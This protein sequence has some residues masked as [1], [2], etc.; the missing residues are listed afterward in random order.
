MGELIGKVV[1]STL[2][3]VPKSEFDR[4]R[5]LNEASA[6]DKT[7]I[8]ADMCRLNTLYMIARAGSGHVGSSFSS[9]DVVSWLYL[10]ELKNDDLYFSSK[11]HDAPGLYSVLIALGK[12]PFDKLHGLRR[13]GGLPGH[14][15]VGVP[16]MVINSG[17]L[18]MGISKAKGMV[19]ADR[20]KGHKRHYY[21]LTGDGELQEGQIWESLISAANAGMGEITAIVDHNKLQSD[22]RVS[23][24]SDLGDLVEKF[25]SFGWYVERCDGHDLDEFASTLRSCATHPGRPQVIIADTVKG[26]GVS[27]MEH[28]AMDSDTDMY[29]FH[30]G[31]PD[32]DSYSKGAQELLDHVN[33]ALS[34]V[35]A[36]RLS[37]ERVE[38]PTKATPGATKKLI[39]AYTEA[40][41]AAAAKDERI[42]ALD[43]DLVLDT[44]LIPFKEKF[45]D[46][47][48]ECGI[49]EMDM[50]SQAGGMALEGLVPICHSFGCFLSTRPNEQIYNNATERTKVLYVGSLAGLIPAAPGH[51][52]Q[53]LRD[54]SALT[55]VPNLD[56]V[57]P[58]C[59]EEVPLLLDY[60]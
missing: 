53:S 16:G 30:S 3:Y 32:S 23:Q 58:C 52:H 29:R 41:L 33:R 18:G 2:Y 43:C 10:N 60:L 15:D 51:S 38:P 59:P 42:V 45:P 35:G 40:L 4:V 5:R 37:L 50:V 19:R 13:L 8:F 12:L 56:I 39:P 14:P 6:V 28:T 9:L 44:G 17:S 36:A 46:R 57:E 24:T 34:R 1:E 27:F 31:A 48:V 25:R 11:G 7:R 47:F 54:I 22:Y 20:L 26:R 21:V 55:S 49:A